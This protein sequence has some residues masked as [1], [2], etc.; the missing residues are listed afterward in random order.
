MNVSVAYS[1][2]KIPYMYEGFYTRFL[3]YNETFYYELKQSLRIDG[4]FIFYSYS[5]NIN[6]GN[7]PSKTEKP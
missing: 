1:V 2:G 6:S 7:V 4:K 3:S 5:L